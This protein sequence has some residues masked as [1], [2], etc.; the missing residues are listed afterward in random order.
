MRVILVILAISSLNFLNIVTSEGLED[1]NEI[2]GDNQMNSGSS[3][4]SKGDGSDPLQNI[5]SGFFG[6]FQNVANSIKSVADGGIE[7]FKKTAETGLQLG[8]TV[9]GAFIKGGTEVVK[10]LLP[11]SSPEAGQARK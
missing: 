4:G 9:S 5:I 11:N 3:V 7:G 10:G 8:K 6:V 2:A 1:P